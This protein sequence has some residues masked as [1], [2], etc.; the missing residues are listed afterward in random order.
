MTSGKFA[1]YYV[2]YG[3]LGAIIVIARSAELAFE[4]INSHKD[5]KDIRANE[6]TAVTIKDGAFIITDGE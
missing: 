4:H 2:D 1:L 3:Y 6:L 5:W